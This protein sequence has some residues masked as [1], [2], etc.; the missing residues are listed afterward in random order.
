MNFAQRRARPPW[1]APERQEM[2]AATTS[3]RAS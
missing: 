2:P 1:R 3:R